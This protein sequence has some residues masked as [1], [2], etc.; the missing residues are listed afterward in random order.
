[1]NLAD[2]IVALGIGG[3]W[4]GTDHLYR[5]GVTDTL[6]VDAYSFARDWRVTGALIEECENRGI[7]WIKVLCDMSE[8][9][10]NESNESIPRAITLA[11]VEALEA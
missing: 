5:L 9:A 7:D 1:M 3:R 4:D 11:T 2:R 8:N 6:P 10:A